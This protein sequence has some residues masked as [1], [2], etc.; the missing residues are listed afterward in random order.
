M[1]ESG[2]FTPLD[3]NGLCQALRHRAFDRGALIKWAHSY[4][5]YKRLGA[6]AGALV[7]VLDPLVAEIG[8]SGRI[9]DWAG[10][11]L[12]RGLAFWRVRVAAHVEAPEEALDDNFFWL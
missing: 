8:A 2:S 5:G 10:V 3:T 11:D 9:P 7:N 12:L 6:G 4:N 1:G